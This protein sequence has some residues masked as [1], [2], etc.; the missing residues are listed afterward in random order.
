MPEVK[1]PETKS[2][3][4]TI[5]MMEIE[6]MSLTNHKPFIPHDSNSG[7]EGVAVLLDSKLPGGKR[8]RDATRKECL[9]AGSR[10]RWVGT[11]VGKQD[12]IGAT[13][14][15]AG[16]YPQLLLRG[17]ASRGA[18]PLI[19]DIEDVRKALRGQRLSV[20]A[21]ALGVPMPTLEQFVSGSARLA[22]AL[23]N[24]LAK[25]L[26]APNQKPAP[27]IASRKPDMRM[28]ARALKVTALL[29]PAGLVDPGTSSPR[30]V[31]EIAVGAKTYSCDVA[32]KS[33]R[34][35]RTTILGKWC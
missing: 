32:S 20:L 4:P 2:S 17:Q 5:P 25:I 26:A 28:N 9:Q 8:L 18:G 10:F 27:P 6:T 34:K 7:D 16:G 24:N 22:P 31:L 29:D 30:V 13:L 12:I 35:C 33:I 21:T 14:S 11:S 3:Q 1:Q 23:L 19:M 15:E